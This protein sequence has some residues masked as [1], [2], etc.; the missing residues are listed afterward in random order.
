MPDEVTFFDLVATVK[1][2]PGVTVEKYGGMI[3]SS[4]FDGAKVLGTLQQKKLVSLSTAMPDQNPITVTDTGKQLIAE[5]EERSK[6]EFDHLDLEILNQV[7]KGKSNPDEIG[8]AMNVRPKDLAMHLYKLYKQD[9]AT[10]EFVTGSV[11]VMLTEKGFTQAKTGMPVKQQPAQPAQMLPQGQVMQGQMPK[12]GAPMQ[13]Q[14]MP[15]GKPMQQGKPTQQPAQEHIEI[16]M[17]PPSAQSEDDPRQ[18]DGAGT[19]PEKKGGH[20]KLVIL[21]II[22]IVIIAALGYLYYKHII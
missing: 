22:I 13:M 1:I 16:P 6:Q 2:K 17:Q 19:M 7:S 10:Y 8:K 4:F 20:M 12:M 5:A 3:N 15:Q 21:V 14:G 11:N 18:H 9:Y